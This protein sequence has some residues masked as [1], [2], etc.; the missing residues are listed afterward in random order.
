[1]RRRKSE[2]E[3]DEEKKRQLEREKEEEEEVE[4]EAEE[5][6]EEYEYQVCY[7]LGAAEVMGEENGEGGDGW[8]ECRGSGTGD[9]VL[10]ESRASDDAR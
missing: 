9:G 2:G 8:G 6:E 5:E 7:A 1:M 3:A 10:G 4:E